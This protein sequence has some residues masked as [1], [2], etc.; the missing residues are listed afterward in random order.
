MNN[1][2]ST[3]RLNAEFDPARLKQDLDTAVTSFKSAAQSGG[4]HD[5]SWTGISLR[6]V[7]GSYKSTFAITSASVSDTE[8]LNHCPYFKEIL[9]SFPFPIGVARLLFLPP[10]KRIG[11]HKDQGLGWNRGVIRLHIPIVTHPDVIFNIDGENVQWKPGEFWFGDFCKPHHLHNKSNV[12]RVHLVI[13]AM[14]SDATFDYF[15]PEISSAIKEKYQVL[16]HRELKDIATDTFSNYTGYFCVPGRFI[17]LP[18][19]LRG[20]I[21]ERSKKLVAKV[22]GLPFDFSFAP[23]NENTFRQL[24]YELQ[25]GEKHDGGTQADLVEHLSGKRCSIQLSK[26]RS[27]MS[28]VQAKLQA[29][30]LSSIIFSYKFLASLTQR[31]KKATGNV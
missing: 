4:Y 30:G 27:F 6:S 16:L 8:V 25:F 28:S 10:G 26:T 24:E 5:G 12:T 9:S 15:S 14:V 31:W 13:D 18:F 3:L 22:Y 19:S 7:N 2:L 23:I 20:V 17:G 1:N 29:L 21:S 11:E